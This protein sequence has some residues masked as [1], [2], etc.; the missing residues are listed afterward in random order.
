MKH[1][2]A[3]EDELKTFAQ[4]ALQAL[5]PIAPGEALVEDVNVAI[6]RP[7]N[8]PKGA[9][10]RMLGA[11]AGKRATRAIAAGEGVREGDWG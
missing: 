4:R 7:G 5:R 2:H 6:L 11:M 8:Q 3:V 9:H 10:P 1:P